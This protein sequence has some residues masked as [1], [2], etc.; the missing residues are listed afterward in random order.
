MDFEDLIGM[1]DNEVEYGICCIAERFGMD[2]TP[3]NPNPHSRHKAMIR[4]DLTKEF[5]GCFSYFESED[6]VPCYLNGCDYGC[7]HC[8][9]K[10]YE[11]NYE[12]NPKSDKI[13]DMV[14]ALIKAIKV[15]QSYVPTESEISKAIEI[16]FD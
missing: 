13:E 10:D 15:D 16:I 8:P 5:H 3:A 14:V 7:K 4:E 2:V 6:E 12:Y 9:M 1:S 11:A